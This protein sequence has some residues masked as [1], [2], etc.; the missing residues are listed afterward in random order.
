MLLVLVI[1][2]SLLLLLLWVFFQKAENNRFKKNPVGKTFVI[3][4]FCFCLKSG[5]AGP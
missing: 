2:I 5:W 1:Y 4:L 3:L